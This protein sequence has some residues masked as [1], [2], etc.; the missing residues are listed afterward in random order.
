MPI[1]MT[2]SLYSLHVLD[3]AERRAAAAAA[4]ARR[5]RP[6]KKYTAAAV[7]TGGGLSRARRPKQEE[8][9]ATARGDTALRRDR[10]QRFHFCVSHHA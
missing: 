10:L 7:R 5:A 8:V 1:F 3:R 2:I 4:P 6:Q 9:E